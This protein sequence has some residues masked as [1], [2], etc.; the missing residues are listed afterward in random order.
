MANDLNGHLAQEGRLLAAQL[1]YVDE[2]ISGDTPIPTR[3]PV[4]L[5]MTDA[6]IAAVARLTVNMAKI[7]EEI[8]TIIEA[9]A[10]RAEGDGRPMV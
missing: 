8:R 4:N 3:H 6:E 5:G 2:L 7:A 9:A 10:K 1:V